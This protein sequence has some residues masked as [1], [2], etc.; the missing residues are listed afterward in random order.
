MGWD[1]R[2]NSQ[3]V[4][5]GGL[6]KYISSWQTVEILYLALKF[7]Y[8]FRTVL[9]VNFFPRYFHWKTLPELN[10]YFLVDRTNLSSFY[11]RVPSSNFNPIFL[12][13]NSLIFTENF[14]LCFLSF[15][16][17]EITQRKAKSSLKPPIRQTEIGVIFESSQHNVM[18]YL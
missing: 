16:C 5:L 17:P 4:T 10:T 15:C 6:S 8:I 7:S 14:S 12:L 13:L 18:K 1:L 11:N 2:S 3:D 9:V